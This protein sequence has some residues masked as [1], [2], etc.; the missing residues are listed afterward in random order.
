MGK[1]RRGN[2]QVLGVGTPKALHVGNRHLGNEQ[3]IFSPDLAN[4]APPR[5]AAHVNDG[6]PVDKTVIR[7]TP[8]VRV[9]KPH[10]CKGFHA[11]SLKT[12]SLA[13]KT[14]YVTIR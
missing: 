7:L 3:R 2:L 11:K 6:R 4:S 5:I 13:E 8:S 10:R 9:V 14:K 1:N 12:F